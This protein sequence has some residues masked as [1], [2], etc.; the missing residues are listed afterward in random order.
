MSFISGTIGTIGSQDGGISGLYDAT[1]QDADLEKYLNV[2]DEFHI[3]GNKTVKTG[4]AV[5]E[6]YTEVETVEVNGDI[7]ISTEEVKQKTWTRYWLLPN[8]FVVVANKGG[9]F[10][11][12]L[13]ESAIDGE[14]DKV[15]FDL[16]QIVRDH[17]GQWMGGFEDRQDNVENGTFFGEDIEYDG[18]LGQAFLDSD[19][20]QIG[21]RIRYNNDDL[22]LRVGSTWFQV[23]SPGEYSRQQYLAFLDEI[24]MNYV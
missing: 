4:F 8:E 21:P 18:D 14:I 13:L 20:N 23:V 19:K 10:A 6:Y 11:F 2:T 24:M 17:P 3:T 9:E 5:E 16:A 7:S 22:K 12:S 15:S 1:P